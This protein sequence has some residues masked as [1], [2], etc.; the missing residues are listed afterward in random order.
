ML[1]AFPHLR[2][3]TLREERYDGM[4]A[5][6]EPKRRHVFRCLFRKDG[7]PGEGVSRPRPRLG[8]S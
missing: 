8:G 3:V 6:R 4:T 7:P 1:R 5:P 2:L